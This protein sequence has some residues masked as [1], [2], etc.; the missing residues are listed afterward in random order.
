MSQ[1]TSPSH[2]YQ[3]GRPADKEGH[4]LKEAPDGFQDMCIYSTYLSTHTS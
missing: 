4:L 3:G 1:E 2:A